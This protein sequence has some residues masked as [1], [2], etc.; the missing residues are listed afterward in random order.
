MDTDTPLQHLCRLGQ[1]PWYDSIRRSFLTSGHLQTLIDSGI[2]GVTVN[3][4]IF[5]QAILDSTD[6][7]TAIQELL[8]RGAGPAA[9]YE[10]LLLEDIVAAADLFRPL[11]DRTGGQDGFVSIEVSPRLAYD[12]AASVAEARRFWATI[13]RPNIMVKVPATDAGIPAIRQLIGEGLNINITLIFAIESYERVMEAYLAGLET[14]AAAGR[15]LDRI[16]SVASFFV[17][18][19]DTEVDRRLDTL[20]AAERDETRR[21][22]LAAVR[23]RAA[24]ANARLAYQ[25]FLTVFA[26][27]RFAAVRAWG[28]RVQRPLW[29]STGTKDPAYSDV[30]YVEELIGPDTVTTLP[31]ATIDAFQD[32]GQV[33]RTIDRDLDDATRTVAR[34]Y[35]AGISMKEV[36][37]QLLEDGVRA[38]ADALDKLEAAIRR[39]QEMLLAGHA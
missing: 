33:A 30:K 6:Y 3:P 20:I 4:T 17:S 28:A 36:T 26:G 27:E 2:R 5:E 1:S 10:R 12:T 13:N 16:A 24:V 29:A 21:R 18:R 39:K 15:P 11:Y 31:Q 35:A 34:L 22:E 8:E 32:H 37:D 14:L 19:V 7:D 23:G 9:I 38:F 25:R